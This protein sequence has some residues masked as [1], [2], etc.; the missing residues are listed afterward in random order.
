MNKAELTEKIANDADISKASAERALNAAIEQI[1]KA[2][3]KGDD[4]QLIG[5]GTFKS[6]K[7]AARIGRNPSTGAEIKIPASRSVKFAV[8]K[9]F[10][11]AVNKRK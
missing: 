11:D 5:F 1:I 4:V 9:A 8:G 10:K 6:G 3:T 2:V 7:R